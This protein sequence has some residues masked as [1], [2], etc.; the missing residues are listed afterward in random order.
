MQVDRDQLERSLS[1][2]REAVDE[3]RLGV[4]GPGTVSWEVNREAVLFLG[5]GAAA[6]LQLAH[7]FVAHA[8]DHHSDTRR[9]PIGRFNRT[10][11]NVY[12]MC[13][14]DLDSA[15]KSA[16]RVHNIHTRI[17]GELGEDAGPFR[18]GDTY[19]ANDAD[20]L[21]WVHATLVRT[22]LQ[23]Y[24]ETVRR[25]GA[26][27]RERYYEES[28]RFA[29]L[30]GIPDDVLPASWRA[31]E[32]YWTDIVD[33][34]VLAVTEPAAEIGRFLMTPPNRAMRG[35]SRW[36]RAV[37]AGLLP[38][39]LRDPFGLRFGRRER[40]LYRAS[41]RVIRRG[42][43]TLPGRLRYVPAYV[44]AQRRL[45]GQQ[46]PD[47]FGRTVEK[48]LLSALEPSKKPMTATAAG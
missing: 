2:L 46:G 3:P 18:R 12:A 40:L 35:F 34:D 10:F 28:K 41:V 38:P 31:F 19:R 24:E 11:M 13:F 14:G 16:R 15:I 26:D 6:L 33:S 5:G 42:Y 17:V 4:H 29:W 20:A 43:G 25:L 23:V 32:R 36:Y 48:L 30:F 21:L 22:S 37:T 39:S 7:P 9:D 45:E 1:R 8:V 47:R 44:E 27:E